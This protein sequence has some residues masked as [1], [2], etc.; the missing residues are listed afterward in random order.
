MADEERRR[1]RGGG[2]IDDGD[3]SNDRRRSLDGERIATALRSN[4]PLLDMKQRTTHDD[5]EHF[6]GTFFRASRL[7]YIGSW[8][9]RYETFL[10]D[11]TTTPP[12]LPPPAAKNG[13]RLVMHV[14][15]DCF[16]AAVAALGRP[17]LRDLPIAVSWSS[18][19]QG[20]LSSCNYAA[21]AFSRK[22]AVS[23]A[24]RHAVR[25]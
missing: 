8:R 6:M 12:P 9:A 24:R 25:V 15:M 11:E 19:G 23:A 4:E 16:F 17:E 2:E 13:E 22:V 20:E 5:P 7:H 3:A 18:G 10:D 1:V 21:R 14:D